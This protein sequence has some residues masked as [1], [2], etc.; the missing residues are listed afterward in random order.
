M[1]PRLPFASR[2]PRSF[3]VRHSLCRFVN[4]ARR[5]ELEQ[6]TQTGR[7]RAGFGSTGIHQTS[8]A[9]IQQRCSS[10]AAAESGNYS[11]PL[12]RCHRLHGSRP[13]WVGARCWS[14]RSLEPPLAGTS[15]RP[16]WRPYPSQSPLLHKFT[17]SPRSE[18]RAGRAS[19][20]RQ[21]ILGL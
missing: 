6:T 19:A 8:G 12:H 17:Q 1:F 9:A 5:L 15:T 13:A 3:S 7:R 14:P 11:F 10:D 4:P 18:H 21:Q 2:C 20:P 16:R